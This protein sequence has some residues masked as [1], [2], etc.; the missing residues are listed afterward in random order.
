MSSTLPSTPPASPASLENLSS[1][2]W[3]E[4]ELLELLLYKLE[5]EQ[6]VLTSG[7]QHWL[8]SAAREVEAV[9]EEIRDVE[10]LRA[11]SVDAVAADLGLAPAPSLADIAQACAEPWRGIWLDHRE[12]FTT[13]TAAITEMSQNNRVLLTA[14]YQAAQATLL[15]MTGTSGTYGADGAVSAA[16]PV[17]M[18]D[19]S[20]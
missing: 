6:L 12:S 16:R 9:L 1:L 17:S 20:L 4:R 2:L 14:G 3:S 15:A 11:V 18:I 19:W 8:A 7:K 10:L 5:V 13:V